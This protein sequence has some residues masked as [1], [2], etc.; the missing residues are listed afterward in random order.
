MALYVMGFHKNLIRIILLLMLSQCFS[1]VLQIKTIQAEYPHRPGIHSNDAKPFS[2]SFLADDL[3]SNEDENEEE[4]KKYH[5][6][7]ILNFN[8]VA[9]LL[10]Q[11]YT[12]CVSAPPEKTNYKFSL[13]LFKHLMVFII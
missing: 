9:T 8:L 11:A 1:P 12:A 7:V 3:S 13:P 5:S 10:N 2:F 4:E 6:F